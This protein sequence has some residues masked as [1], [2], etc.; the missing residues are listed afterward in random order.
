MPALLVLLDLN[1]S[2]PEF[3]RWN[4]AVE[5]DINLTVRAVLEL[6]KEEE[7]HDPTDKSGTSPDVS[8]LSSKIPSCGIEQP[9]GQI[10]HSNLGYVVCSTSDSSAESAK[11]NG[12]CLGNDGV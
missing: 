2:R 7:C 11:T 12:R 5:Q 6:R 3:T 9:L 1:N 4:F 10:D 8:T